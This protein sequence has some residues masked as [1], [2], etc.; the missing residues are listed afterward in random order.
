MDSV[1]LNSG[2][3]AKLFQY[4]YDAEYAPF[5]SPA[6]EVRR[7][8]GRP[9]SGRRTAGFAAG[10]FGPGVRRRFDW[11]TV[12]GTVEQQNSHSALAGCTIAK[13]PAR[14]AAGNIGQASTTLANSAQI[15]TPC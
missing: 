14:I 5:A 8:G 15:G 11:P 10:G 12:Q 6:A 7:R 4:L 13:M 2:A 1:D 3:P 9:G